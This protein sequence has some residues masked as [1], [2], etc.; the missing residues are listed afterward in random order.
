MLRDFIDKAKEAIIGLFSAEPLPKRTASF[1]EI[2]SYIQRHSRNDFEA[3]VIR[4]RI[5]NHI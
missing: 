2:E 4:N 3:E 5:D 1:H